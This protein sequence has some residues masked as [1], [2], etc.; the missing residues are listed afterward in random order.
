MPKKISHNKDLF[1][2]LCKEEP[3]IPV[4][5]RDWWLD[6]TCGEDNWQIILYLED[7]HVVA[8]MTYFL[9]KKYSFNTIT[10]PPLTKFNGPYFL[11][12]FP[13][14]K[15]QSILNRMVEE[16]PSVSSFSQTLHYQIT[17][18]LPY[19][20]KGYTQTAYYSYRLLNLGQLEDIWSNMDVDYRNNKIGKASVKYRIAEDLDF[21][22]LYRFTVAPFQRQKIE[23]PVSRQLLENLVRVCTEHQSGKGLFAVDQQENI[24]GA[25]F[26]IWDRT[27]CYLLLAGEN[28]QSRLD[29]AGIWLTWQAIEYAS[30]ILQSEVFDFL[31]GMSENLERTRRQYG[32]EQTPYFL[33]T[34]KTG[35]LKFLHKF[36]PG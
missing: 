2:S 10:V 11:K 15:K 34:R 20:W 1:R 9:K 27:N 18:W 29:G 31:G 14:R 8:F 3:D 24:V 22:T 21:E 36:R 35:L 19:K 32:A 23:L 33:I 6:V 4:F 5:F 13:E 30:K 12:D 26:V 25:V 17:N 7:P 28:E 16:I